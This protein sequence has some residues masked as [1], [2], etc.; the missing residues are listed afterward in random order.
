[1]HCKNCHSELQPNADYCHNCGAKVIKNRLTLRNLMI[2]LGETFF[3][4]DNKLFRT[5]IDLFKKP[6]AVIGS[7]VDGVRMRYVNPL[8]FFGVSLTLSG[9][10]ILIIQKFYSE[11]LNY[12]NM[13]NND[14]YSDE[15]LQM[16]EN[17]PDTAFEYG[18]LILSAMIPFMALISFIV[19]YNKRYNFTE[20]VIIY[21]YSMSAISIL[22]VFVGQ[23]LLFIA[24]EYYLYYTFLVYVFMFF[25]YMYS[26]QRIFELNAKQL[27]LKTLIFLVVFFTIFIGI[28]IVTAIY[29]LTTKIINP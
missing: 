9:L 10:S 19:F 5:F 27:I 16:I 17:S 7:Y 6:E 18:S 28:I 25:Y 15:A 8:N 3:N 23:M 2:H 14:M 11:Y 20:H 29:M 26:L 12:S 13:F 21:I 1:M 24:P 22:S 4:Y